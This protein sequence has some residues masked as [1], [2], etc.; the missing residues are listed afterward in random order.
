MYYNNEYFWNE[1]TDKGNSPPHWTEESGS[2][3]EEDLET[4]QFSRRP[5]RTSADLIY[6]LRR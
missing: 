6:P 1:L 3:L 2:W 5:P 4:F